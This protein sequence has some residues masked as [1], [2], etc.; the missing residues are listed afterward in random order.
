MTSMTSMLLLLLL[1][2]LATNIAGVGAA[3]VP[4]AAVAVGA[5]KKAPVRF[6]TLKLAAAGGL[7]GGLANAI[8][9]PIDTLKT[10]RQTDSRTYSSVYR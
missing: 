7:A 4:S 8:L 5:V 3:V 1:V 2:L 10:M 6:E 9:Y